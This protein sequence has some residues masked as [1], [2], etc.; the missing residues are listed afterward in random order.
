M[1]TT[2]DNT[3]QNQD[4]WRNKTLANNKV[5]KSLG[6]SSEQSGLQ[7][8]ATKAGESQVRD[9]D[10]ANDPKDI[11]EI[12]DRRHQVVEANKASL[13][14][15]VKDVDEAQELL[16]KIIGLVNSENEISRVAVVH[17]FSQVKANLLESLS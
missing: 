4:A 17:D 11:V 1:G 15:R 3:V 5:A 14:N 9:L 7:R 8:K 13:E 6:K 10:M 16:E 2:I 12:Q